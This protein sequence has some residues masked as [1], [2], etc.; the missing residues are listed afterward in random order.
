MKLENKIRNENRE[1]EYYKNKFEKF[2]KC[3]KNYYNSK[4]SKEELLKQISK[5]KKKQKKL[6]IVDYIKFLEED[7]KKT[8]IQEFIED[9]ITNGL[10]Y[11]DS[12]ESTYQKFKKYNY[13]TE[14]ISDD[15]LVD[16]LY[17]M[18][19]KTKK[20]PTNGFNIYTKE[21]KLTKLTDEYY[22]RFGNGNLNKKNSPCTEVKP[23]LPNLNTI[24]STIN[25]KI[26]KVQL[27]K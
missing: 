4:F 14:E 16:K 8:P 7:L 19:K 9:K 2:P 15:D 23:L 26:K 27:M 12:W 18:N 25:F 6:G 3:K 13:E 10:D 11:Y 24:I 20:I 1:D 5:E 21:T 17:I 22:Y